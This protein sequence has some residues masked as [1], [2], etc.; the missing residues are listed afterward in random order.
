M[1]KEPR[2]DND[3][4]SP[5]RVVVWGTSLLL[6]SIVDSLRAQVAVPIEVTHIDPAMAQAA[7]CVATVAPHVI[8][9]EY[10]KWQDG[11]FDLTVPVIE[12]NVRQSVLTIYT[13]RQVGVTGIDGLVQAIAQVTQQSRVD[14]AKKQKEKGLPVR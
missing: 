2:M 13:A 7:T 5:R 3:V 1:S 14:E 4:P 6:Y 11:V 8:I 12:V 9:A 10:G